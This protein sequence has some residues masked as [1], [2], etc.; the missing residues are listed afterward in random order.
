MMIKRDVLIA[1]GLFSSGLLRYNDMDMWFRLAYQRA[2]VGYV[3]DTLAIAHRDIPDSIVK[4]HMNP[5]IISGF[6]DEHLRL[7]ANSNMFEEAKPCI[8]NFF[9]LCSSSTRPR[10]NP[11]LPS[12]VGTVAN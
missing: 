11:R 1:A 9:V 10:A 6:V 7:A 5:N 2:N 8:A 3:F 12:P 4:T